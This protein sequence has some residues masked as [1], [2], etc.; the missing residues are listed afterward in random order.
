MA[1]KLGLA[2]YGGQIA[3]F[4]SGDYLSI[5]AGGTG[6]TSVGSAQT[7]LSLVPGTNIQAYSASL[8]A[9]AALAGTGILVQTGT[10]TFSEVSIATAS[11]TRLTVTNANGTAG[12]PTLDLATVTNSGT[13]TF[14]KVTSDSYGRVTGTQ[15]VVASDITSL[16]NSSYVQLA[17]GG[18]LTS[19]TI[20]L[21]ADPVN[22]MDAA[23]KQYVDARAAGLDP[24]ASV[25]AVSTTAITLNGPQTIDGVSVTAGQRV[26]VNGQGGLGVANAA[27][28]I[29]ICNASSW[30]LA[31]DWANSTY[32]VAGAFVFV[33]GGT[34]NA[35]SGWVVQQTGTITPGT[36]PEL[37][38]QFSGAGEIVAGNGITKSGNTLSANFST[39]IVN[40]AGT[41]DLQTLAIGGSGTG[42]WTSVTVDTYG[43]VTSTGTATPATIGAQVASTSLTNLA[44]LAGTGIIVQTGTNTFAE[45]TITSSGSTIAVTNAGGVAGNINLDLPTGVIATPGTYNSVTVDTYGRVTAGS[46][47]STGS[48]L[49]SS[50]LTNSSGVSITKFFAVYAPSTAHIA[51]ANANASGT[52]TVLGLVTATIGNGS[53]GTVAIAGEL[54]GLT[55]E[56]DAVTQQTGGLTPGAIYYLQNTTNGWITSTAP[57]TGFVCPLGIAESTTTMILRIGQTIQL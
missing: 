57:S 13:G 25:V 53:S 23:T 49:T 22:P 5:A 1:S 48:G 17:G 21:Y 45:R 26:L 33:A 36:T 43:R 29:Y 11:S 40:N 24:K 27:N 4:Q 18:T 38:V 2:L 56:W 28:G 7:A 41:I 52:S 37:W 32:A 46:N 42:T 39:R 8:T 51:L 6:G 9:L 55:T 15:A 54:T 12:N 50:S 44:A 20:T 34:V 19:G 30:T 14:Q 16:V 47:T 35:N 31:A 3:Q 10:N